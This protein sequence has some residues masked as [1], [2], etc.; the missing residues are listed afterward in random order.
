MTIPVQR[1][2]TRRPR[3]SGRALRFAAWLAVAV[4][5]CSAPSAEPTVTVLPLATIDAPA[6]SAQLSASAAVSGP[7]AASARVA[8]TRPAELPVRSATPGRIQCET[9]DCDLATEVCCLDETTGLG[10]CAPKAGASAAACNPEEQERACDEAADCG[11]SA[12]CCRERAHGDDC[13]TQERWG[14]S[15][16]CAPAGEPSAELCLPGSS[17]ASG[18]CKAEEGV[19]GWPRQGLCADDGVRVACGGATCGAGEGCCFRPK[20]KTAKCV[21]DGN[22]CAG[23]YL[24]GDSRKLFYCR[25]TKDCGG[26]AYECF[27]ATGDPMRHVFACG[28][29]R[30]NPMIGIL[31]PYLCDSARDCAPSISLIE[32]ETTDRTYQLTGCNKDPA[33]PSGVK[34]CQYK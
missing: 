10:R 24:T 2:P 7:P 30:C 23:D 32:S 4:V 9:V 22:D 17:C 20:T 18:P 14:C 16:S 19:D 12:H 5:A 3:A 27:S 29:V 34:V 26:G 28:E 8:P 11:G 25:S 13:L 21:K 6:A 31:G 33:Y 1:S 15:A